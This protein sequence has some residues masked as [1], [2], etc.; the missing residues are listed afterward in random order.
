MTMVPWTRYDCGMQ[1]RWSLGA[2]LLA[3]GCLSRPTPVGN[4]MFVS[5]VPVIA[6]TPLTGLDGA[7]ESQAKAAGVGGRFVAWMSAGTV[8]AKDRL[9]G[10]RGWGP[11]PGGPLA[12]PPHD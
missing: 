1:G 8:N 4:V 6:G 11:P 9:A 5:S 2:A 10:A 7:C 3:C 12:D